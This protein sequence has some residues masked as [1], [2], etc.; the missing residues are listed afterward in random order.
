M[1]QMLLF[2]AKFAKKKYLCNKCLNFHSELHEEHN[3]IN[4]DKDLNDI[5]DDMCK[6]EGHCNKLEFFC[7]NHNSLCCLACICRIKI[8]G[9]GQH[10]DCNYCYINDIQNKKKT[11]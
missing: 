8:K 7:K 5:F 9:Y 1:K 10:S 4:L 2:I 11:N 3:I 6:S